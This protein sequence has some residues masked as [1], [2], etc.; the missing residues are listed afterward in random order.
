M[1][2]SEDSFEKALDAF[3]KGLYPSF[4]SDLEKEHPNPDRI[5]CPNHS[6]LERAATSPG[7]LSEE[8]IATF[9]AHFVRCWPCFSEVKS[10]IKRLQD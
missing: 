6:L 3:E 1:T 2:D 10:L 7:D 4:E 8:E 5:G 9:V